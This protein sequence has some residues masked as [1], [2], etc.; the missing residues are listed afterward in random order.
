M[1]QR[2]SVKAKVA[3]VGSIHHMIQAD[4]PDAALERLCRV[5]P[6]RKITEFKAV[7]REVETT[8]EQS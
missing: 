1:T 6:N 4:T 3:G 5:Y 2:Y 7:R 8:R